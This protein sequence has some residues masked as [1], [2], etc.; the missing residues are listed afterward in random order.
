VLHVGYISIYSVIV[1]KRKYLNV[2][3]KLH[4]KATH[5]LSCIPP[6]SFP[7]YYSFVDIVFSL[8]CSVKCMQLRF[9]HIHV[10]C[11]I[12]T[13]KVDCFPEQH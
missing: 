1:V 9:H 11:V 13:V 5:I 10:F 3:A 6:F 7:Q 12:C 2:L 8:V 4:Y